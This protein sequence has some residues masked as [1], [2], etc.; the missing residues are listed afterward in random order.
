[1]GM[2]FQSAAL[3]DS[4]TVEDNVGFGLR[5]RFGL[6]GDALQSA[7]QSALDRVQLSTEDGAKLPAEL[8]G[9]MRKRVGMARAIALRP[10]VML[11]DEPTTG[12]DPV[13]AAAIDEVILEMRAAQPVSSL[14]VSHDLAAVSRVADRIGF[15]HQGELV[16]EGT[17]A[18]FLQS[19]HP[20]I[21][22]LLQKAQPAAA[23]AAQ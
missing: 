10:S 20:A 19:P 14:L 2:V 3:F 17:Y 15:L 4:M 16:F 11:Y 23:E 12:L 7:V 9:G 21:Q 1:M 8:S 22:D 5:R 13:T 18:E 6:N